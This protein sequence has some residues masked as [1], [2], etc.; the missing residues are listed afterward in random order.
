ML[1]TQCRSDAAVAIAAEGLGGHDDAEVRAADADVDD[2][3][4]ALPAMTGEATLVHARDELADL[5]ELRAHLGHHVAPLDGH[6]VGRAIAQRHVQRGAALGEVDRLAGEQRPDP[7]LEATVA[8]QREQQRQRVAGESLPR[9]VVEKVEFFDAQ[10]VEAARVVGKQLA[11]VVALE[12]GRMGLQR[13]P[14]GQ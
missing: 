8:R 9:E 1:E 13:L 6:G 10:G 14:G 12:R 2:V 4:E 5:R 3:G 11:Q 7:V